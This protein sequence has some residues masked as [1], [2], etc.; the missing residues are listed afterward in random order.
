MADRMK[1]LENIRKR[2]EII[3]RQMQR[4]Q[5][6]VE[7]PSRQRPT[8]AGGAPAA[9]GA[10]AGGA[11]PLSPRALQRPAPAPLDPEPQPEPQ[12]E[13]EPEPE[14]EPA[15]MLASASA[16]RADLAPG[17][18]EGP[19]A[20][21]LDGGG[22]AGGKSSSLLDKK[23]R[24][25]ASSV[26]FAPAPANDAS[27]AGASK[28]GKARAQ[29]EDWTAQTG[30]R[31]GAP[32]TSVAPVPAAPAPAPAPTP[33]P[34]AGLGQPSGS[35]RTAR[36]SPAAVTP[37]QS[38]PGASSQPSPSQLVVATAVHQASR[39]W[40][41]QTK[42]TDDQGANKPVWEYYDPD[43][44]E[45][46]PIFAEYVQMLDLAY[47]DGAKTLDLGAY[48]Y[49][50]R[51]FMQTYTF[52]G[53]QREFRRTR[54]KERSW[55]GGV[56]FEDGTL[57]EARE[58]QQARRW[59]RWVDSYGKLIFGKYGDQK[60]SGKQYLIV[61][62]NCDPADLAEL[63]MD[64]DTLKDRFR[65][66]QPRAIISVTGSA[67][68][69]DITTAMRTGLKHDISR[70]AQLTSAFLVTGGTN[71]GCMELTGEA[72]RSVH[73]INC[74]GIAPLGTFHGHEAL[75][76]N[77]GE[78]CGDYNPRQAPPKGPYALL[79]QHH[80]HFILLDTKANP[81]NTYWGTEVSIRAS[82]ESYFAKL[83][84]IDLI[85]LVIGGGPGTIKTVMDSLSSHEP[86]L[87]I[88]NSGGVADIL[89]GMLTGD[90]SVLVKVR[91][92]PVLKKHADQLLEFVKRS[93]SY[94]VK[95]VDYTSGGSAAQVILNRHFEM[96]MA[97]QRSESNP[98]A[99]KGLDWVFLLETYI[100]NFDL[101]LPVLEAITK[102]NDLYR[103][104]RG[105][106][107]VNLKKTRMRD[108]LQYVL[109]TAL[110]HKPKKQESK[111]ERA[112][113]VDYVLSKL[114]DT[115]DFDIT[116]VIM[117][118]ELYVLRHS[119]VSPLT[120]GANTANDINTAEGDVDGAMMLTLSGWDT[121]Y[122]PVIVTHEDGLHENM[123]GHQLA[124]LYVQALK[125]RV[126]KHPTEDPEAT[127]K[128]TSF[129]N[130]LAAK[131]KISPNS[132][133]RSTRAEDRDAGNKS[134]WMGVLTLSIDAF[135][136][137]D[138]SIDIP[139]QDH[140]L[141]WWIALLSKV[142]SFSAVKIFVVCM[143]VVFVAASLPAVVVIP[144]LLFLLAVGLGGTER[145][146]YVD[147]ALHECENKWSA[148]RVVLHCGGLTPSDQDPDS[149]DPTRWWRVLSSSETL[150]D[151]KVHDRAC[152][153]VTFGDNKSRKLIKGLKTK[154]IL[155]L[156]R[157]FSM[158]KK[159]SD[160]RPGGDARAVEPTVVMKIPEDIRHALKLLGL[161]TDDESAHSEIKL[162]PTLVTDSF[163]DS[164]AKVYEQY[165]FWC[166]STGDEALL[167]IFWQR[168]RNPIKV[169]VLVG[170]LCDKLAT[171]HTDNMNNDGDWTERYPDC[172]DLIQQL[173]GISHKFKARA[174]RLM[175]STY[176]TD[177]TKT[178]RQNAKYLGTD[179][180][181]GMKLNAEWRRLLFVQLAFDG[182]GD[183][184]NSGDGQEQSHSD[185]DGGNYVH[186]A[187]STNTNR[188]WN[189]AGSGSSGY[190][191]G[192]YKLLHIYELFNKVMIIAIH[193]YVCTYC[194]HVN[195]NDALL[196]P[197]NSGA[198][199]PTAA[200]VE[201]S[202]SGLW[203]ALTVLPWQEYFLWLGHTA[204]STELLLYRLDATK[205]TNSAHSA[206]SLD[207]VYL[208]LSQVAHAIRLVAALGW[209]E[210]RF[211]SQVATAV[212]LQALSIWG[213]RI[214]TIALL[215]GMFSL[216]LSSF[217]V[218]SSARI[219]TVVEIYYIVICSD[220][221]QAF[222]MLMGFFC[223]AF[224]TTIRCISW[225]DASQVSSDPSV[226][227]EEAY[228]ELG[229]TL[230]PIVG[231][232]SSW[233]ASMST[234]TLVPAMNY[235][236][237]A[238]GVDEGSGGTIE[239]SVYA[240]G[241]FWGFWLLA[242]TYLVQG[243]LV[244]IISESFIEKQQKAG[245]LLLLQ[246]LEL[247]RCYIS[248]QQGTI[249]YV[250][251]FPV[252]LNFPSTF[253][254]FIYYT[255]LSEMTVFGYKV[256]KELQRWPIIMAGANLNLK[257]D[258]KVPG[259]RACAAAFRILF[260]VLA[261]AFLLLVLIVTGPYLLLGLLEKGSIHLDETDWAKQTNFGTSKESDL[262]A[263]KGAEVDILEQA[264]QLEVNA[265]QEW[266]EFRDEA[267]NDSEQDV[268]VAARFEKL[269]QRFSEQERAMAQLQRSLDILVANSK[270][271]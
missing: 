228:V 92:D 259:A 208:F 6:V 53:V 48:K 157:S 52:S 79:D 9:R 180:A 43:Q 237:G 168:T 73:G 167:D 25:R 115:D 148:D 234:E 232:L 33:T 82:F 137:M 101:F 124:E 206:G 72:S 255:E 14:P 213:Q 80:S 109:I 60:I 4:G 81:N 2:K 166:C 205:H 169:A 97:Q 245:K 266:Q 250:K 236:S 268:K 8:E 86:I 177:R 175:A 196:D 251:W 185:H 165:L 265:L 252:Y 170:N 62:G 118:N 68:N 195:T 171:I 160:T 178:G 20:S 238:L 244:G 134:S 155:K 223:F 241:F 23:G 141:D 17:S 96:A 227:V 249:S 127:K 108:I 89:A 264:R 69:L 144:G 262:G 225:M 267:W 120:A 93:S 18:K 88:K 35:D 10:D 131:C 229:D 217:L 50:F 38:S 91:Q 65:L 26:S 146:C 153:V 209:L 133:L 216:I 54:P 130:T 132:A 113:L 158:K 3:Q 143:L 111:E 242:N 201:P 147:L 107:Q 163:A 176:A 110:R 125:R 28:N 199:S 55:G 78:I 230:G 156:G 152:I 74:I 116:K 187:L 84:N 256:G 46:K 123:T 104:K 112:T 15:S 193:Y 215:P 63:V 240:R 31:G 36:R 32:A 164:R 183:D 58:A 151:Q 243:F 13:P 162:A 76:G 194:L 70:L 269:E 198:G 202:E 121:N 12:P 64:Q 49:D 11:P 220:E 222:M 30:A 191:W 139:E 221:N 40:M 87:I 203:T 224:S 186:P 142:P 119:L 103:K 210:N 39:E 261:F 100:Y 83:N 105:M 126:E 41:K 122:E 21:A 98:N 51:T 211:I 207:L 114:E 5:R 212:G 219:G 145:D 246:K 233:T 270:Q 77:R 150:K 102:V 182:D 42:R 85:L 184:D 24:A 189:P 129:L 247:T 90:D 138:K 37:A 57:A 179:W 258:A 154:D 181:L 173:S 44:R 204:Q 161:Y 214:L 254:K 34:A 95:V 271:H 218:S 29:T 22:I 248:R 135:K 263:G 7:S 172:E 1:Q 94:T 16:A 197:V 61:K 117:V 190:Q 140:S 239:Q 75:K 260:R 128:R 188:F 253:Y 47:D 174:S 99:A 45:W 106:G 136:S 192:G 71:T 149:H 257:D 67:A 231:N 56:A 66:N 235:L 200:A 59:E 159:L 226:G 27:V 19:A